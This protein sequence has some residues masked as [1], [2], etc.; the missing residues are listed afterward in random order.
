T[1]LWLRAE[2]NAVKERSAKHDALAAQQ[3][4]AEA[5]SVADTRQA[6]LEFDRGVALCEDGQIE[7]GMEHLQ[8]ARDL[9][10]A[11][12]HAD[13][14]RVARVQ[15]AAWPRKLS[16]TLF[17]ITPGTRPRAI[18]FTADGSC[19]VSAG[20]DGRLVMWD[21]TTGREIRSFDAPTTSDGKKPI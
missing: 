17:S 7:T 5:L 15:L 13:L 10:E 20:N 9:A 3:A 1:V 2:G 12:G 21:A 11:T 16:T 6:R 18:A 8:R 14:A 19:L 4:A